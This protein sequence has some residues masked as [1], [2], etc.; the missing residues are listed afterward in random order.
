MRIKALVTGLLVAVTVLVISVI[1]VS[2]S[3]DNRVREV[4]SLRCEYAKKCIQTARSFA[5]WRQLDTGKFPSQPFVVLSAS[6]SGFYAVQRLLLESITCDTLDSPSS[7]TIV[8]E[9]R[10]DVLDEYGRGSSTITMRLDAIQVDQVYFRYDRQHLFT[11]RLEEI[12][13]DNPTSQAI[14]GLDGKVKRG[15]S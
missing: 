14:N 3:C 13:R 12:L 10:L 15:R 1:T 8:D 4:E 2:V 9:W 11:K 7:S 6:E 5:V